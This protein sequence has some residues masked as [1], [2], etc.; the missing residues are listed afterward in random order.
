VR[1]VIE[2]GEAGLERLDR[3]TPGLDELDHRAKEGLSEQVRGKPRRRA[4]RDRWRVRNALPERADRSQEE[5]E[6]LSRAIGL[7]CPARV[8]PPQ[9]R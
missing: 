2:L 3:R 9:L 6:P 5:I 1:P 4:V 8:S 7:P